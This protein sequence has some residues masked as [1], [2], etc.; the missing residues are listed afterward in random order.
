MDGAGEKHP[1]EVG[2]RSGVGWMMQPG[3]TQSS[4]RVAARTGERT[5]EIEIEEIEIS[6]E[7]ERVKERE[8]G[9]GDRKL[10]N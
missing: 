1:V 4:G 5:R 7:S 3:I 9:R 6:R 2:G 8:R 10:V